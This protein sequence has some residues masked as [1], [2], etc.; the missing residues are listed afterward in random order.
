MSQS[1][2]SS[3]PSNL[4]PK[5]E[6]PPMAPVS[7]P[8]SSTKLHRLI[9][10]LILLSTLLSAYYGFRVVQWKTEVGG[11][12]NLALGKRPPQLKFDDAE[13]AKLKR[14]RGTKSKGSETVEDRIN[15]LA[16]ALGME[17]KDLASAIAVAV[18]EHVPPASLSSVAAHQTGEAVDAL[19]KG[20]DEKGKTGKQSQN[21]ASEGSGG[22]VGGIVDGMESFVGMDEP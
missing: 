14:K 10:L 6:A 5:R 16:E 18:R 17:S 8:L 22:V 2:A 3:N 7:K 4:P 11:W 1:N 9:Y 19:L 12:W 21:M 15:A 13:R 20:A